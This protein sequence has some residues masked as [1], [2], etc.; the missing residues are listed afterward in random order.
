M[1]SA[2]GGALNQERMKV[3][4][5]WLKE[6]V[7]F[8]LS[9]EETARRLTDG[10]LEV[11]GV[12]TYESVKGGLQGLVVG[13]VL[14]C[15][16]HP[17]S[18]H[19][20]LTTVDV[21]G[22]QPLNIVCGAPNVAAGQKVIVAT[23]GTILYNGDESFTIKKSKIRGAE[24]FGMI[25][26]EDEIGVGASHDGIMVLPADTPV[27]MP[28]AD[29]FKIHRDT[30][31]E[32][33]LTP[34]RADATSHIGVA[35]DLAAML[36][37][38]D[39]ADV[40]LKYPSAEG[41]KASASPAPVQVEVADATLCPRYTGLS[42]KNVK[43]APSPAWM[44]ERLQ[45]VG[46]R[47][48]NNVVD[49]TNYILM[50]MGQPMHAFDR[51]HI[52]GNKIV[53]RTAKAGE[54]L[55]TLDGVKRELQ[56]THLMI[57]NAEA[58]MCIAGVFGGEEAGVHDDTT[59]I[60]LESAYFNPVSIRK[61]ARAHGLNTDA[62]FRYERGA[63]PNITEYALKRAALLLIELAGAE[64]DGAVVD[65][66]PQPIA[67]PVVDLNIPRMQTLIGKA[68]TTEETR[69]ILEAMEMETEA[70]SAD[71]LRVKVPT[72]KPD[73]T[74]EADLT[75]EVLR[76]YGYNRI[77]MS[78]RLSYAPNARPGS[79]DEQVRK[80]TADLLSDNG[81]IEIMN[82]SLC[83]QADVTETG[84]YAETAVTLAN[85]LSQELNVLR[86][87][88][89][90]GGL[91]SVALNLNH[92]QNNLKFY[93][94]GR[95][96]RRQPEAAAGAPVTE[97][98]AETQ[99][100][101]LWLTGME[102]PENWRDQPAR[103]SDFYSLKK[104]VEQVL[105]SLRLTDSKLNEAQ[106]PGLQYGLQYECNGKVLVS[107]GEVQPQLLRRFDLKQPVF[108]A[109]FDW[110]AV[111][112]CR[113]VKPVVYKEISKFPAVKR[114]LALLVNHTVSFKQIEAAARQAEKALLRDIRLFDVY[115]GKN[116]PDGKKSYAVSFMLQDPGKTLTDK[117]IEKAMEKIFNSLAQ[118]TGA[119][120][121]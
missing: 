44:R 78:E 120:L 74:R 88:L 52:K 19:L 36:K 43:I 13:K 65:I 61:T 31:L 69:R 100:L 72:N 62:S 89:L 50:E 64:P 99:H 40:R 81:F 109:D 80:R 119:E 48:I 2:F 41:F 6:Y 68:I 92:K 84:W 75:E 45:S 8:D 24:S 113:P 110:D 22:E 87:S 10:G 16:A 90:F 39:L 104:A 103:Q 5:S 53:V 32:I 54:T 105:Q 112:K 101:A 73:V 21:G 15:E 17:D 102:Q 76:I 7:D 51:R 35:R 70:V 77:E 42:L 60:F 25:C 114:D 67:R 26:A 38:R 108:Y 86:P 107:F 56:P 23:I 116:L 66:Y 18:D 94:F 49:V 14:T 63:D 37:V 30:V 97:R 29:Y 34:N 12:E 3:A 91:A 71:C 20:H 1:C 58:P 83:K 28:A 96:Y 11:E 121:R 27:G 57:C 98:F 59:E 79:P 111:L 93:E 9:A 118:Q 46:I 95:T 85:P 115:E 47:P 33:G 82:N 4:Y 117:Q 106:L 55:V